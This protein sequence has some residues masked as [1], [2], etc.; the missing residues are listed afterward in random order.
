MLVIS[1]TFLTGEI[2]T[3]AVRTS[4]ANGGLLNEHHG[5]GFK[6]GYLMP[7]MYG[8]AWP[9][10]Q[11]IKDA[12]DPQGIM[13]PGKLGFGIEPPASP[14]RSYEFWNVDQKIKAENLKTISG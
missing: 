8:S 1:V 12:I 7:E 6:L 2:W 10:L 9:L 14:P 13:N 11:T 3:R 4:L 5:I